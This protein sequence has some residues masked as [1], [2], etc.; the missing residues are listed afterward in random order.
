[1]SNEN[2]NEPMNE[3]TTNAPALDS[4]ELAKIVQAKVDEQLAGIKEK[5]NSAYSQRDEAVAKAV[6][7]EEKQK[8]AEIA[9]LEEQGKHKEAAD[10]RM[11]ELTARL[12]ERDQQVTE[13]TRDNAVRDA[14][15]GLDFR[16]D[17]AADFAYRD[18][19]AQLTQNEQG[20]WMHKTG[21]SIKDYIDSFRKDDDKEFLFK[22]KQSSGTGQSTQ[23]TSTGGFDS[24]KSIT[25][26]TTDEIMKAAAAGHFDN[27]YGRQI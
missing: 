2:I 22:P 21:A 27:Q 13:L 12:N 19:V 5:L 17:T 6:G 18:V 11:A 20:Q 15:K 14:L 3:E 26:M 1:M 10:I 4:A 25:E 9:Q 8:Q 23:A 16:N 7:F 24:T